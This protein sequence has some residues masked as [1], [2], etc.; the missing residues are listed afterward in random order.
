MADHMT[1]YQFTD[2]FQ[3]WSPPSCRRPPAPR[4]GNSAPPRIIARDAASGT[5][6]VLFTARRFNPRRHPT[7]TVVCG[8]GDDVTRLKGLVRVLKG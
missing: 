8:P 7:H 2:V 1:V 6:T 3:R 5:E 4:G